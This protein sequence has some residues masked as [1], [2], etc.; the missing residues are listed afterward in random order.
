MNGGYIYAAWI[1][2]F[3]TLASYALVTVIRGRRLARRVPAGERRWVDSEEVG[4]Q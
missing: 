2:V 1:I 4:P 3:G